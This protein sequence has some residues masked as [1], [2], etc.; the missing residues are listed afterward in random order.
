M[1]PGSHSVASKQ[2]WTIGE[3]WTSGPACGQPG[4]D[5]VFPQNSRLTRP[6]PAIPRENL[7]S[8]GGVGR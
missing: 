2:A 3:L 5:H 4:R 6:K 7:I 8:R 1:E